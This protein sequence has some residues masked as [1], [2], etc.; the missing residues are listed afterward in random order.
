MLSGSMAMSLYMLPRSTHDFDFVVNLR[1]ED[2]DGFIDYFQRKYYCSKDAV[3][4]AIERQGMFNVIDSVS[5]FKADFV[6]RKKQRIQNHR[7]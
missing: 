3:I 1:R 6:I 5:G 2:A 4:D 7:V